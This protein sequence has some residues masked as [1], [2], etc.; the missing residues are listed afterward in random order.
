MK[1]KIDSI[2]LVFLVAALLC[3]MTGCLGLG[4]YGRLSAAMGKVTIK[5]LIE[6]WYNYDIYYAGLAVDN[7]SAVMFDTKIEGLRIT[8]DKWIPV[9]EKSVLETLVGWLNANINFPPDLL[10][11]LGPKG[12]FFGY[13]YTYWDSVEIKAIDD[14]TLW[15]G[16]L[17]L[18]P[19]DYGPTYSS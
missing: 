12:K 18:P 2:K 16:D 7:P 8:S 4:N 9:T 11:I 13:M 19:M 17:P 3:L 10:R 6:N 15:I 5:D 1:H 14:K